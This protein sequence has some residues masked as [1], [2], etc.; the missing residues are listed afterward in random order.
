VRKRLSGH[1][2]FYF[3]D[4]GVACAANNRLTAP[5]D[6]STRGRAFEHFIIAE[7]QRLLDYWRSEARI[8][9]WRTSAGA[10]V[11]CVI[12][13]HGKLIAGC[14]IKSSPVIEG[15][16]TS[17]LRSFAEEHPEARLMVVCTAERPYS[18]KGIAALPWQ[19]YL[20][21]LRTLVV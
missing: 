7:T 17:G 19:Q 10:E 2:K 12:E 5:L 9:Y 4:L 14:E 11:D 6:H 20:E 15:T 21:E 16:H 13:K 3:F 18:I 1:P 8:Y